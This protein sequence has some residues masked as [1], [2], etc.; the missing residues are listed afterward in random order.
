MNIQLATS[1]LALAIVF[2]LEGIFPHFKGRTR[3]LKHAFPNIVIAGFNGVITR[4][5]FAGITVTTISWAR[6]TSFGLVHIINTSFYFKGIAVFVLFDL[7]MYLWHRS[8]H[9]IPFL[10]RFHRVHH[11]DPEMDTTTAL[12]FH[13]V[14]IV[15]SSLLRLIVIP[16]I[17]LDLIH[18]L[19]YEMSMQP[20]IVFHHSNVGL[21][22][23]WDR[24][25]RSIIVTPNMHR[26]HHSQEGV[27]FNSN[28]STLFSF[29]DRVFRTFRKRDNTLDIKFGLRILQEPKWQKLWGMLL[30][31]FK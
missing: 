15:F 25:I 30:T 1:I 16:L 17:G 11:T 22:E 7:W 18:L 21:P 10:W 31:P 3:R 12:R 29:W 26:V 2:S 27:E 24:L 4:F 6:S 5:L 19:I 13:P 28:Y 9:R 23:R 14:E 20:V 8:N